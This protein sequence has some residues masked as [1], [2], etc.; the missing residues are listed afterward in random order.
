MFL[1]LS[2]KYSYNVDEGTRRVI[3]TDSPYHETIKLEDKKEEDDE[4]F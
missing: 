4:F 1:K 3:K 2:P